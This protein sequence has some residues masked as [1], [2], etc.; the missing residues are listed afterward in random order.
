M[1]IE[2]EVIRAS[3]TVNLPSDEQFQHWVNLVA[4]SQQREGELC[5]RLVD[6]A[7]SE[8]LNSTYRGKDKPTNVLSFPCD[9][10]PGFPANVLGDLAICA[11]VVERESIEQSKRLEHHWAHMVIHGVLHLIG[12]D[13]I[14]DEDAEVM[15][16][17][18]RDLLAQL[19]I[20]DPYS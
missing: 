14:N 10:P 4:N 18:E 6:E 11:A 17:L 3:K 7:E 12:F 1:N 15:E 20:P 13:H 5:I 8:E 2:L 19:H 16:S 9:L